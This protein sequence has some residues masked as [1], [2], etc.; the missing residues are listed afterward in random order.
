[1]ILRWWDFIDAVYD[2][3]RLIVE[4]LFPGKVDPAWDEAVDHYSDVEALIRGLLKFA[5]NAQ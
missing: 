2:F 3:G 4:K 5:Y 1:M